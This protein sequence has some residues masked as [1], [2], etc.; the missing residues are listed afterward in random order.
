MLMARLF[1]YPDASARAY[2]PNSYGG[3]EA[4]PARAAEG[5]WANDGEL[6]RAAQTLH[7]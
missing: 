5:S 1:S 3:P 2:M 7:S 4:D 6:V